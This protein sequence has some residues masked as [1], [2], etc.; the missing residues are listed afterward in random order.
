VPPPNLDLHSA[1]PKLGIVLPVPKWRFNINTLAPKTPD[2]PLAPSHSPKVGVILPQ[3]HLWMDAPD[4]THYVQ[5]PLI[6]TERQGVVLNLTGLSPK[7]QVVFQF[8]KNPGIPFPLPDPTSPVFF[9]QLWNFYGQPLAQKAKVMAARPSRTVIDL[10]KVSFGDQYVVTLPEWIKIPPQ[11]Y[12]DLPG[13]TSPNFVAAMIDAASNGHFAL[14]DVYTGVEPVGVLFN[15]TGAPWKDSIKIEGVPPLEKKPEA[16]TIVIDGTHG[17]AKLLPEKITVTGKEGDVSRTVVVV[18]EIEHAKDWSQ[19]TVT[20]VP[21]DTL[22]TVEHGAA[23]SKAILVDFNAGGQLP[24]PRP[25]VRKNG[26][27]LLFEIPHAQRGFEFTLPEKQTLVFETQG[28]DPEIVVVALNTTALQN[29]HD[30]GKAE[31]YNWLFALEAPTYER[32]ADK[33][34]GHGG[35]DGDLKI[36][37][38]ELPDDF[39]SVEPTKQQIAFDLPKGKHGETAKLVATRCKGTAAACSAAV[40]KQY[41]LNTTALNAKTGKMDWLKDKKAG[42]LNLTIPA[43]EIEQQCA[44]KCCDKDAKVACMPQVKVPTKTPALPFCPEGCSVDL[45]SKKCKCGAFKVADCPAGY[46]P[47]GGLPPSAFCMKAGALSLHPKGD[48]VPVVAQCAGMA[49]KCAAKGLETCAAKRK[50]MMM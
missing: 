29:L 25:H 42:N 34:V 43:F 7:Q 46:L 3:P 5:K 12:S 37:V 17:L 47:C 19:L 24:E 22:V 35:K 9:E 50:R 31:K 6:V 15:L 13:P 21:K 40:A 30:A 28:Y 4:L 10:S 26:T 8:E 44:F 11:S 16:N 18:P 14:P 38:V 20:K 32:P 2:L 1:Q 23:P 33:T 49:L 48:E 39:A 41:G 45:L 36:T 27:T